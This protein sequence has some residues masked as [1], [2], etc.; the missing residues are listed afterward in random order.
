MAHALLVAVADGPEVGEGQ[1]QPQPVLVARVIG[2]V[3]AVHTVLV[4]LV[5]R[6]PLIR[7]P[8]VGTEAAA[9]LLGA[10][11]RAHAHA[12]LPVDFVVGE[13]VAELPAL[14]LNAVAAVHLVLGA[15]VQQVA[16]A[17]PHQVL[18]REAAL[19]KMRGIG[20]EDP[21]EGE[22]KFVVGVQ[23][24]VEAVVF[25]QLVGQPEALGLAQAVARQAGQV[26][27]HVAQL[28]K[29]PQPVGEGHGRAR[30]QRQRQRGQPPFGRDAGEPRARAALLHQVFAA[31]RGPILPGATWQVE[32]QIG[33][34]EVEVGAR[35]VQVAAVPSVG[36]GARILIRDVGAAVVAVSQ[37]G[38][39][40]GGGRA[41]AAGQQAA[42]QQQ[43][44]EGPA[45]ARG[46]KILHEEGR[47]FQ[48][49]AQTKN[50]P[51]EG[52]LQKK[53]SWERVRPLG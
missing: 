4:L 24:E 8:Q 7:K 21:G 43:A 11:E 41:G 20:R 30:P 14:Q 29:G 25:E 27:A 31:E 13:P 47:D 35:Y 28:R 17:Q 42:A 36:N 15:V 1:G 2:P 33:V 26:V 23:V 16:P 45:P 49:T 3:A 50:R 48:R 6:A 9:Q 51:P 22:G 44:R 46:V 5:I 34:V 39:A 53:G 52:L 19:E 10:V 38:P 40:L 12:R 37:A 18:R 32:L